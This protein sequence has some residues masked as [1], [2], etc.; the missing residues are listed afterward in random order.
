MKTFAP[1]SIFENVPAGKVKVTPFSSQTAPSDQVSIQRKA[2]CACGGGCPA[3]DSKHSR[4]PVSP[5]NDASEIEADQIADK[6]MRA[7]EP[8]NPSSTKNSVQRKESGGHPASLSAPAFDNLINSSPGRSL[9]ADTRS[10]MESRFNYDFGKVKI[11]DDESAAKSARSVNALAYTAGDKIVFNSGQYDPNSYSGKRLLAHELAHVVQQD[12]VVRRQVSEAPATRMTLNMT[13]ELVDI[14]GS[15]EL[16][17]LE[18]LSVDDLKTPE[19]TES[20]A[21]EE[22]QLIIQRAPADGQP[23][24][25]PASPARKDLVFIMGDKGG[26]FSAAKVF[27]KQHH[28]EA[29][30]VNFTDRTLAGIFSELRKRI[31]DDAPAGNIYIVSHANQDGTLTFP[32]HSKDRDD[33][34]SF[35]ELK[36]AL[37]NN[38]SMFELNGGIDKDTF[39]HIK[40]CNIGRNTDMLNVLDEAFGGEEELDAPTH[41]QGYKFTTTKVGGKKVTVSSEF[42][43]KFVVEYEGKQDKNTDTLIADFQKRYSELGYEDHEWKM[44]VMG[45]KKYNASVGKEAKAKKAEIDKEAK[46]TKKGIDKA[47]K[48]ALKAVDADTKTSKAEVDD[49]LKEMKKSKVAAKSPGVKKKVILKFTATVYNDVDPERDP[50]KVIPSKGWKATIEPGYKFKKCTSIIPTADGFTFEYE[51]V[52]KKTKETGTFAYASPSFPKTDDDVGPLAEAALAKRIEEDPEVEV[53]RKEM[54]LWRTERTKSKGFAKIKAFLEM[55]QY[56]IDADMK[57]ETGEDIDPAEKK[58]DDFYFGESAFP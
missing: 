18:T 31:S 20:E 44:M 43:N 27:F 11:Y 53:A 56:T 13:E 50:A 47:D 10:F 34:T 15:D 24:P 16:P 52:N 48:D 51:A 4:L 5:A 32:L 22:P 54:Y 14:S 25:S 41:R 12:S 49:W 8:V 23:A 1:Q 45:A 36:N 6:V 46:E 19:T 55:T 21:D 35:G 58:D 30:I 29:Q 9:D 28:P 26:F 37:E 57:E 40:G 2:A 33:K 17:Q 38:A 39:V 7:T 3:C 42:F